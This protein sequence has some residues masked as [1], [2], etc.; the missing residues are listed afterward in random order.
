MTK[1]TLYADTVLR[2]GRNQLYLMNGQGGWRQDWAIPVESEQWLVDHYHV[3]VGEWSQDEHG[4]FCPVIRVPRSEQPTLH[5]GETP[6][7]EE[8]FAELSRAQALG[9]ALYEE[10]ALEGKYL[11]GDSIPAELRGF[12]DAHPG[13]LVR[14]G[15][16]SFF[17]ALMP[18]GS[19][20]AINQKG[21]V[22]SGYDSALDA[23]LRSSPVLRRWAPLCDSC[24]LKRCPA[25]C[26][27]LEA[28]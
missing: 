5:E 16:G 17:V 12:V 22:V 11:Q 3:R 18:D 2:K 9:R 14:K 21:E 13:V 23:E 25:P 8:G 4:D 28:G 7:E 10:G 1:K 24:E 15:P 20:M 26:A 19:V 27:M 6:P